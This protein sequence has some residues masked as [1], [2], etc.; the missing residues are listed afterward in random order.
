[1]GFRRVSRALLFASFIA[2]AAAVPAGI[3]GI[4]TALAAPQVSA[5][6]VQA[7]NAAFNGRLSEASDLAQR[8]GDPAAVKLVELINLRDHWR[9][10]GYRRIMGFLDAAPGWPLSETLLK[11]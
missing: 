7:A 3:V 6:A 10:L 2:A 8:S 1:M 9:T 11:R 5:L 4:P